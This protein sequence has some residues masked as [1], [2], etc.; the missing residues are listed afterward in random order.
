MSA[1]ITRHKLA[2]AQ[3]IAALKVRRQ[4]RARCQ[5]AQAE[6]EARAAAAAAEARAQA[7]QQ[8]HRTARALFFDDPQHADAEVWLIATEDRAGHA[9]QAQQ[10]AGERV[11]SA[12]NA[13]DAARKAHER[14]CARAEFVDTHAATFAREQAC[15]A[16]E[17]A[18]EDMQER[19]R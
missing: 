7:A 13:A 10:I 5:A 4:E 16:A 19:A 1:P 15:R 18:D 2:Q 17:R 8:Q 3:Q 9:L 12:R 6:R 14:A 11:L